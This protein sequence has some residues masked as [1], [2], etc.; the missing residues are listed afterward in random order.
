MANIS[1]TEFMNAMAHLYRGELSEA[2]AWRTRI[3][4]TSNW[5]V[6]LSVTTLSF[7]FADPGSERHILIPIVMLFC[8][9]LLFM[10]ARRY[11]FYDIWRSRARIIEINFYRPMLAGTPPTMPNWADAL[12]YDLEWPRFHMSWWEAVGR[13]LRRNYQWIYAILFAAWVI[14]LTSHPAATTDPHEIARRAAIGPISG[15]AVIA[16]I[17]LFYGALIALGIYSYW[18]SRVRK[19]LPAGH[20]ERLTARIKDTD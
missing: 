7:V 12:A 18:S 11:R 2:T 14:L 19:S 16:A 3:D 10:E 1:R 6:V 9:F 4:T 15:Y 17:L 5:A 8:T 20:P 13:R